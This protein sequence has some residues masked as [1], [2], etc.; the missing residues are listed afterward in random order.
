MATFFVNRKYWKKGALQREVRERH[1]LGKTN[2]RCAV[3]GDCTHTHTPYC[4]GARQEMEKSGERV[5]CLFITSILPT[6]LPHILRVTFPPF[7]VQD[8]SQFSEKGATSRPRCL[9]LLG[10][11]RPLV[12]YKPGQEEEA[13][14]SRYF[15]Y[16]SCPKFIEPL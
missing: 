8:F 6:A 16:H 10:R 13:G 7:L 9:G 15:L 5:L 11:G 1:C 14:R 3:L 2:N 12:A 4:F